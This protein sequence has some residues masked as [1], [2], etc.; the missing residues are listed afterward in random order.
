MVTSWPAC[1]WGREKRAWQGRRAKSMVSIGEAEDAAMAMLCSGIRECAGRGVTISTYGSV[2]IS[3]TEPFGPGTE[4]RT[5]S[6]FRSAITS[7]I[8]S[9][10]CVTRLLP[11]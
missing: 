3:T 5:S 2:L 1:F 8:S 10:R 7:T 6:R 9:P 11:I 4:P